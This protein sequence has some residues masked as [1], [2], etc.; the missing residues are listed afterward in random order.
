MWYLAAGVLWILFSDTLADLISGEWLHA[1]TIQSVKGIAFVVLSALLIFWLV[2]RDMKRLARNQLMLEAI[3]EGT[4]DAVFVKN[5]EGIYLMLN[6]SGVRFAGRPLDAIVGKDDSALF[7]PDSASI[8][9]ENDRKVMES[10]TVFTSIEHL[11]IAGVD[12]VFQATKA[13]YRDEH[14]QIVGIIGI[15]RDIT[16]QAASQQALRESEHRFRALFA[17]ASDAIFIT[18]ST[19][20]IVDANDAASSMLGYSHDDLMALRY[21]DLL[22]EQEKP[23]FEQAITRLMANGTCGNEWLFQR[24][25]GTTFTGDEKASRLPDGNFLL[26]IRDITARKQ[27]EQATLHAQATLQTFVENTPAAIAMLDRDMRYLAASKR[28]L[29]DYRLEGR[30]VI[31]VHHYDVFP[32]IRQIPRWIDIHQR[33]L[34]GAIER[35]EE[36]HFV[37][38]DGQEEWMRWEVHPWRDDTGNIGGIIMFTE[39][40]TA[41][42]R[43][44]L[45]LLASEQRFRTI[46]ETTSEL[47]WAMDLQG[48][49][50]FCNPAITTLLGYL[51]EEVVGQKADLFI[52]P[53]D[54]AQLNEWLAGCIAQK[55]GWSGIVLRCRHKNGQYRWMESNASPILSQDGQL[56]GYFGADRDITDRKRSE[57]ALRETEEQLRQ[58]RKMQAIGQLAGGIAHDFNNLLTVITGYCDLLRSQTSFDDPR[59]PLLAG[60]ADAGERASTLT[61][62]L[63]AFSRRQML[64]PVV[65]DLNKTVRE[66]QGM[67]SRL[68]GHNME[69]KT[70]FAP[71]LRHV[72]VDP[73]QMGQVIMNLA[74]N[75]RDAM[76][77]GGTITLQT[78][79]VTLDAA[80]AQKH[81]GAKHGHYVMLAITDTGIG[82]TPDIVSRLFEPFF[83]TKGVGEGTGLGLAVVHGIVTQSGGFIDVK[84]KP[85]QGSTFSI[86]LPATEES[87]NALANSVENREVHGH[88]TILV[89]EDDQSVRDFTCIAL[90]AHGYRVIVADHPA[91]A[92]ELVNRQADQIDLVLTDVMMPQISGTKLAEMLTGRFP[93]LRILFVSGYTGESIFQQKGA[94]DKAAFLQKPFTSHALARK[95]RELLDQKKKPS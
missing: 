88:E 56:Q 67:L 14:G 20:R 66:F 33:C 43:E 63:L 90:K 89:V 45:A 28:W 92:I 57:Q 94:T 46:V 52:H 55:R 11:N 16:S 35:C 59:T 10:G 37:R 8:I 49:Y 76:P 83:T 60:I 22:A 47:I 69:L 81:P 72:R 85:G 87:P 42:K 21:S 78:R 32:E 25:D 6:T 70:D 44:A 82:M 50:T 31:G 61:L 27:A 40:I 77:D 15:S 58:A 64:E 86:Y 68:I 29:S 3:T 9:R 4:S 65:V 7:P 93:E 13:P 12:R 80:L 48:R 1:S 26:C 5:K 75:A 2:R 95:V 23:R 71:D 39:A 18:A 17:Y 38:A 51:P 34:A 54:M 53:E 36:D 24:K 30:N 73:G 79:N 62:Q 41:R 74:V 84:S 91:H 19:G